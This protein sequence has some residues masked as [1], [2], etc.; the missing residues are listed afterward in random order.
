MILITAPHSLCK[1]N[2]IKTHEC[3]IIAGDMAKRL[4]KKL[5]SNNIDVQLFVSTERRIDCDLNRIK[6]RNTSYR[7]NVTKYMKMK[8]IFLF[9]IHSFP[10]SYK[11]LPMYILDDY[12]EQPE[13]YSINLFHYLKNNGINAE[14]YQGIDNDI[15]DE[16][17]SFNIKSILIEFNESLTNSERNYIIEVLYDWIVNYLF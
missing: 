10:N 17:R 7:K 3:D 13:N 11:Q 4:Y 2:D 16:A 14:L 9:D 6:C 12:I 8:P 1:D 15:E 5:K